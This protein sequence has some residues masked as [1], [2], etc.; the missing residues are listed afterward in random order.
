MSDVATLPLRADL[1][2]TAINT[3]DGVA[4]VWKDAPFSQGVH[5]EI[6]R[7]GSTIA[8]IVES[9]PDLPR[10]F[11]RDGVVMVGDDPIPRHMWR[12]VRPK[13]QTGVTVDVSLHLPMLG[14]GK[15]GKSTLALIGTIA[16]MALA[17]AVSGGALGAGFAAGT[18]NAR[19][20]ALAVCASGTLC[21]DCFGSKQS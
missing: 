18:F 11:W 12:H 17:F 7:E 6:R 15:S 1:I 9:I 8:E 14:G 19:V 21:I 2:P 10:R 3:R 16:I 13:V 4:I 20:A 5:C